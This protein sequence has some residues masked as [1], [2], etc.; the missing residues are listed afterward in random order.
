MSPTV[1]QLLLALAPYLVPVLAS[2][3]VFLVKSA[4]EKLP[5]NQRF[6][7]QSIVDTAVRATEQTASSVLTGSG[8][9]QVAVE[10]VEA[11]LA[12]WHINIPSSVVSALIEE[13]V[14]ALPHSSQAAT[15]L[16]G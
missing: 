8:K 5:V 3:L 4:I 9:K 15:P 13:A 12:H 2:V 11:E 1:S 6:F 14:S 16:A 10:M 7:V